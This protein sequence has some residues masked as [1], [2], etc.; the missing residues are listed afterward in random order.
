MKAFVVDRYGSKD[1]PTTSRNAGPKLHEDDV[2]VQIHAADVEKRL[3]R[4]LPEGLLQF[5]RVNS[6]KPYLHQSLVH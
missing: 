5:R 3:L 2:L 4:A 1:R 6:V